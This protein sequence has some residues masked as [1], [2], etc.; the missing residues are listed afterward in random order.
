MPAV[1]SQPH[2]VD[3][4]KSHWFEYCLGEEFATT[5]NLSNVAQFTVANMQQRTK[6]TYKS[7]ATAHN[8]TTNYKDNSILENHTPN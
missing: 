2:C 1:L 5:L 8:T 4:Y 3:D 6:T 7:E